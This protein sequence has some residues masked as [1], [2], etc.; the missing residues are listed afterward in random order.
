[1]SYCGTATGQQAVSWLGEAGSHVRSLAQIPL[2]EGSF[3]T[4]A[5]FGMLLLASEEAQRFYPE[6]GTLYLE[7]IGD[8]AAAAF[9][10]VLA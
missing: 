2:R 7:Q 4:G 1:L 5:C 8:I 6:M 9:Q 10:R 3:E